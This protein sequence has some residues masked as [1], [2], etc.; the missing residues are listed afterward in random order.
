MVVFIIF[1]LSKVLIVTI[2]NVMKILVIGDSH[3]N[4]FMSELSQVT[5]GYMVEEDN[6]IKHAR[7]DM[8][9][10]RLGPK[11][12]YT[13]I[14]Y[15]DDFTNALN[16]IDAKPD[17]ALI[18]SFGEIDCRAH[19]RNRVAPDFSDVDAVIQKCVDRYAE[20]IDIIKRKYRNVFVWNAT[21]PRA[22]EPYKEM[23]PYYGTYEERVVMVKKFNETLVRK[24]GEDRTLVKQ[25]HGRH[26]TQNQCYMD[27]IHVDPIAV[28]M[29][30]N[31]ELQK[32][33]KLDTGTK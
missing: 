12:A 5:G 32:V 23:Y 15:L 20:G 10:R 16:V 13:L 2:Y 19:I 1:K 7:Y 25:V 11:L 31:R 29:Y 22:D 18:L 8:Y 26:F 4:A 28:Q 30:V 24:F 21:P 27:H 6:W 17:D 9:L 14:D 33:W 3:T